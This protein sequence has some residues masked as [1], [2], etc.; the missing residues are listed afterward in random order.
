MNKRK[1]FRLGL[2]AFVGA[3]AGIQTASAS[4]ILE[5][6]QPFSGTGLGTVPTIVT[7]QNN[8]TE[9]GC[10]GSNGA[11]NALVGGACTSG[12]DTKPGASQ[13]NLQPLSTA[14]ITSAANFGLVFNAVQPSGGPLDV[15][16]ITVA[17]Y[18]ST[19][20][21]IYQSSGLFCQNSAGGLIVPSGSGCLLMDTAQGTGNSG[22][23]VTLDAAQQQAATA[24]GAFSST[25]NLVGASAAAGAPGGASAGGSETIFLANS[26]GGNVSTVP[27]PMSVLLSG[28]G[29]LGLALLRRRAYLR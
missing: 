12:G 10:F 29:L 8:G 6:F 28:V 15:T 5:T 4:L 9:T 3:I 11:G 2:I 16:N 17:F 21:F 13:T 14:G 23:L 7:F 1:P 27:E 18:D 19:G 20:K 26:G 22:F 25:G 24:A